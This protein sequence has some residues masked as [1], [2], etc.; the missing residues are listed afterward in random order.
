[1]VKKLTALKEEV[2]AMPEG[3]KTQIGAQGTRLSGGQQ[4]RLALARTLARP[5]PVWVLD[6]PFS[7]VDPATEDEIL[8]NLREL[9]KRSDH[10]VDFPPSDPFCPVRSSALAGK[11]N[12]RIADPATMMAE[13]P[14]YARLVKTQQKESR[15]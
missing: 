9:G 11:R 14:A 15:R 13:N 5:R 3:L 12:C 8:R 2:A 1:M 6:D 4:A 10:P 7:A